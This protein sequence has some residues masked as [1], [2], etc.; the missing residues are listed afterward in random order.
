MLR[1]TV[2]RRVDAGLGFATGITGNF[3]A[4]NPTLPAARE[5]GRQAGFRRAT[6]DCGQSAASPSLW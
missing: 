6:I 2:I 3:V 5:S 4:W 1:R